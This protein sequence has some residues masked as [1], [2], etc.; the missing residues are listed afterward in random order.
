MTRRLRLR[1]AT[2]IRSRDI[3]CHI[4]HHVSTFYLDLG[5]LWHCPVSWCTVWTGTPQDCIDHARGAHDVDRAIRVFL[6][7]CSCS[8]YRVFRRGLPHFAF[9]R[10]YLDKLRIF[11]S[12]V[13]ALHQCTLPSPSLG[14]SGPAG[15]PRP[16]DGEAGSPKKT[17]R[18][19]GRKEEPVCEQSAITVVQDVRRLAGALV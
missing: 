19:Q 15:N 18:I 17:H 4:Y 9:R 16:G 2:D 13:T 5:Q 12:K 7:M 6:R 3:K 14:S 11:V 10:D 1:S 8:A